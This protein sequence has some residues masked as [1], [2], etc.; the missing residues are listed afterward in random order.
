MA[1]R[2]RP[3]S[4]H[5]DRIAALLPPIVRNLRIGPLFDHVRPGL[6][7]SQILTLLAVDGAPEQGVSMRELADDL[8]VT[9][10]TTTGLVGRLVREGLVERRDHPR[11]RRVVL[12]R[13]TADGA[14]V[15][16]RSTAYLA[17]VME[18]VLTKVQEAERELLAQAVE[19]VYELSARIQEEQRLLISS[20]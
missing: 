2:S 11:D 16:R 10:P 9:V 5:V 17:E 20:A 7:I 13:L 19:R 15:V 12:V 6:S 8:G 3:V 14:V 4:K 1:A 18:S